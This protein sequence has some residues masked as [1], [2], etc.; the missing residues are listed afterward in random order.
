ME[1]IPSLKGLYNFVHSLLVNLTF[2][3]LIPYWLFGYLFYHNNL[4]ETDFEKL[5][6]VSLV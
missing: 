5:N 4:T 2:R 6:Y 3:F 1:V